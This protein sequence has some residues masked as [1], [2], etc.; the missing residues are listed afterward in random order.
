[1]KNEKLNK[2]KIN[3]NDEFYTKYEDISDFVKTYKNDFENKVI[4]C[5]CDDPR[6]SKI[7]EFFKDNF[8][9]LNLK[10]IVSTFRPLKEENPF[11]T[12]FDGISE[13]KTIIKSGNFEDNSEIIEEFE[14]E[15]LVIT[16]PPFSIISKY[17]NFISKFNCK[18]VFIAPITIYRKELFEYFKEDKI[19]PLTNDI[20]RRFLSPEGKLISANALFF[21]NLEQ[22]FKSIKLNKNY[23]NSYKKFENLDC[24]YIDK[25]ENIPKDY[26]DLMAVPITSMYLIRRDEIEIYGISNDFLDKI[27]KSPQGYEL[28]GSKYVKTDK[29]NKK[30]FIR[31][32]FNKKSKY[33]IEGME[34][35]F[36]VPFKRIFIKLK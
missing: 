29:L 20:I 2:A 5:N 8:K 24:L 11:R 7:Y 35:K 12:D 14:K 32:D 25:S 10:R 1:M 13:V 18:F 21:G 34:G 27:R 28:K 26:K 23:D 31:D 4:Y 16:N 19:R 22:K 17:I 3:R 33:I 6:I 36:R 15:L 9:E 30:L